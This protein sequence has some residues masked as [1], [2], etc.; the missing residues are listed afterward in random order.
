MP[1]NI[2]TKPNPTRKSVRRKRCEPLLR[3]LEMKDNHYQGRW[4]R[5]RMVDFC[6]YFIKESSK[7]YIL[8]LDRALNQRCTCVNKRKK[9]Q[10]QVGVMEE[11]RQVPAAVELVGDRKA[12]VRT[13]LQIENAPECCDPLQPPFEQ[14]QPRYGR[15]AR[16]VLEDN[17][18]CYGQ[19]KTFGQYSSLSLSPLISHTPQKHQPLR[20]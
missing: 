14:P 19:E 9:K 3:D 7:C 12:R 15:R 20:E 17:T 4:D 11:Y 16:W 10:K 5:L 13:S 18:A 1:L 8:T 6:C 2:E